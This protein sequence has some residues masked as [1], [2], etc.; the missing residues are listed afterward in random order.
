MIKL[1]EKH[2]IFLFDFDGTLVDSMPTYGRVM[3]S[4]LDD[5][6]ISYPDDILKTITPLGYIGTTDYFIKMGVTLPR[7]KIIETMAERM[8]NVYKTSIEE[9]EGVKDTLLRLKSMGCSLNVLTASPHVTLDPCLKRIGLF[10]LFDNVWSCNDFETTKADPEIYRIAAKKLDT[11][12]NHVVFIDDNV[13]AVRTAK[14]AGMVSVGIYDPSSHEYIDEMK[15][16]A[17]GYLE[18][19]TQLTELLIK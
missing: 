17:D 12:V 5:A 9:K 10:E 2:K 7:E 13:D 3:L 4:I 16:I 14:T 11:D 18:D 6:K 19:M 1:C 8:I 15:R